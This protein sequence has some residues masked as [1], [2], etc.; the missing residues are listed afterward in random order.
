MAKKKK[1]KPDFSKPKPVAQTE[2]TEIV[3]ALQPKE[4][5]DGQNGGDDE[6]K[7]QRKAE[8]QKYY[9]DQIYF[10]LPLIVIAGRPNVG[11][12]TLF[13][14]L[15]HTKRAITDPTPGGRY[16]FSC[17]ETRSPYGHRRIQAYP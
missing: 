5:K 2:E 13:N 4:N 3:S 6:V 15:T 16:M 11:K 12:S 7:S 9:P 1:A 8:K 10:N 17:R 14:V